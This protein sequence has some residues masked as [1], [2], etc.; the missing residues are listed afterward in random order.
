[1]SDYS[2]YPDGGNNYGCSILMIIICLVLITIMNDCRNIHTSDNDDYV[3]DVIS[4]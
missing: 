2:E 4:R 1:M 3:E